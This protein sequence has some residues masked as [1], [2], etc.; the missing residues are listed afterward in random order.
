MLWTEPPKF[1]MTKKAKEDMK[2]YNLTKDQIL[3]VFNSPDV[4]LKKGPNMYWRSKKWSEWTIT[5]ACLWN[6]QEK[7]WIVSSCWRFKSWE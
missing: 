1:V 6:N 4:V 3:S 5:I 2:R 7:R